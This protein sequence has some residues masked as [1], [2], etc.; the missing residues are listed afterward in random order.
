MVSYCT[1][2]ARKEID[3]VLIKQVK[4]IML[5]IKKE[6]TVEVGDEQLSILKRAWLDGFIEVEDKDYD[7][8]RE[9]AK[10]IKLL[11]YE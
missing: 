2:A 5:G 3:D 11:P 1:L 8:L 4:D 10:R 7:L 9:M 6:D